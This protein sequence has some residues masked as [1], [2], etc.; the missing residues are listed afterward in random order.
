MEEDQ[1][2]EGQNEQKISLPEIIILTLICSGTDLFC[3]FTDLLSATVILAPVA[4]GLRFL[5]SGFSF[6]CTSIWLIIR[7]IK[8]VWALLG[9][10]IGAI[11][12]VGSFFPR[13]I[14]LWLT[15]S[16]INRPVKIPG[17]EKALQVAT[18]SLKAAK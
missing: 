2:E 1:K 15:I 11:P 10:F 8:G 3:I 17:V 7:R 4:Q 16:I 12:I 18:K 9:N 13:T 5:A 6:I 14:T